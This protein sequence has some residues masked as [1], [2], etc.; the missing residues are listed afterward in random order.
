MFRRE[1]DIKKD[2]V[3]LSDIAKEGGYSLGELFKQLDENGYSG[4][5]KIKS[6]TYNE[7][8]DGYKYFSTR[9]FWITAGTN[10]KNIF[11]K[12][13]GNETLK[14]HS[15]TE[16]INFLSKVISML[17]KDIDIYL[18][19]KSNDLIL[20][21]L[22][23]LFNVTYEF[24]YEDRKVREKYVENNLSSINDILAD[25]RNIPL[26][27][28][29]GINLMI[30]NFILSSDFEDG[31]VK[32]SNDSN[33][34][35]DLIDVELM[36]IVYLYSLASQFYTLLHIS[37]NN[38]NYLY[39]KG[40]EINP[41]NDIP[42]N[43]IILHPLVYSSPLKLGNQNVF[44]PKDERSYI[45]NLNES[46][47]GIGFKKS[48]LID[49]LEVIDCLNYTK[50]CVRDKRLLRVVSKNSLKDILNKKFSNE[51]VDNL[52]KH[53][54][55]TKDKLGEH[56][57]VKEPYIYKMGCNKNRLEIRPLIELDNNF[58]YISVAIIERAINLWYSM[59]MN[60]TNPYT[61]IAVGRGDILIDSFAKREEELGEIFN[62]KL[63]ELLE[64]K[65]PNCI[66][67]GKNIDYDR[68]FGKLEKDYGDF[69]IIYYNNNELFLIEAKYF[70][71]SYT[72]NSVVNDF[73]KMFV[74]EKN[75]YD[76]C[77]A[78]YDLVMKEPRLMKNFIGANLEI[79]VHCLFISSKPLEI[80]FQDE[81]GIVTFLS[82]SNFTD[83]LDG[84]LLTEDGEVLRPTKTI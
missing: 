34:L 6:S 36:K 21:K 1:K 58:M 80:E 19:H 7:Y 51:T 82:F 84:R 9:P 46:V 11:E 10:P 42:I 48:Y 26:T 70:S 31:N 64:S 76:H 12:Y 74:Y 30:E 20:R 57:T 29:N 65:Y 72:A 75:Y 63:F 79:N 56:I 67:K 73:N 59:I 3:L 22:I 62:G 77:R 83:Y 37:K 8:D 33:I 16:S 27:L 40:I 43:G 2:L 49:V 47:I 69:D 44:M 54:T 61:G 39:C 14:I 28:I 78:R 50:K 55:L 66:Y 18:E 17:K 38:K 5:F 32:I 13:L 24:Y 35:S 81:D 52:F 71:D 23:I 4:H 60:G 15:I 45:E 53:F 41:Q 25:N 68:I